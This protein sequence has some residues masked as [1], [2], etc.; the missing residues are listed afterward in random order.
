MNIIPM[1]SKSVMY[2]RRQPEKTGLLDRIQE[3]TRCEY[4]SDIHYINPRL[5][6]RYLENVPARDYS[7]NEW[8]DAVWYITGDHV[9]FQS[10]G[11]A[12]ESILRYLKK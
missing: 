4:L 3:W 9:M 5:L 8:N 1:R 11:E 2:P 7:L 12:R 10:C 6:D